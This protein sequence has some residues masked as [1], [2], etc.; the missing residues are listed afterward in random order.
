MRYQLCFCLLLT[1]ILVHGQAVRITGLVIDRVTTEPLTGASVEIAKTKF[2]KATLTDDNGRF[3]LP[4]LSTNK[5]TIT[6]K[7][8]GYLTYQ[9]TI[10]PKIDTTLRVSLVPFSQEL[11][12]VTVISAAESPVNTAQSGYNTL[13]NAQ[14]T[15]IPSIGSEHDVARTLTL[16]PGVKSDNDGSAGFYV[17][18]GTTDQNLILIDGTTLYKNNHF[19]GFLSPLNSDAIERLTLYKGGFP[20]RFGG[21]LSSVLD[22][23]LKSANKQTLR[24]GG[25]VGILSSRFVAEIPLIKNRVSLFV[26]GRR[27]YF[28]IFTRLFTG[29]GT[30]E[31][32][33]YYFFDLNAVVAAQ[34]SSRHSLKLFAY[35]DKDK[36]TGAAHNDLEDQR[37]AQT[38]NSRILGTAFTSSLGGRNSN[39]VEATWSSYQMNLLLSRQLQGQAFANNFSTAIQNR[40]IRNTTEIAFG[41]HV[42]GRLGLAQTWHTFQ[43]GRLRYEGDKL[44]LA[45][46]NLDSLNA[47]ESVIFAE[48]ELK[49]AR[50]KINLGWRFIRYAGS[51]FSYLF[52]EP[53]LSANVK[54]TQ[55]TSLKLAYARMNQPLHLLSNPGL[56][57]PVDLWFSANKTIRP[58]QSD[59]ISLGF[60]HDFTI[61]NANT[62]SV[63]AEAYYKTMANIV[64]YLDGHSSSDFTELSQQ[65]VRRWENVVTAGQGKSYGA[66]FFAEKKQ[67]RWTGWLSYTLSWTTNQ[68]DALN[69]GRS[70]FSRQDRRNAISLTGNYRLNKR[71]QLNYSW[72]CQTGQPITLPRAVYSLPAYNFI[73]GTFDNYARTV[74]VNGERNAYRM[75]DYHRL[76][77]SIQR[78]TT[79]RWGIGTWEVS[80]YNLY[81]RKN[82]YFYYMNIGQKI[83]SV[84]LFGAIPSLSYTFSIYT[85]E[86]K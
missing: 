44:L 10:T 77:V 24:L 75:K 41:E 12:P 65:T 28:D 42:L 14:L 57:I 46:S 85:G 21:R 53:R 62:I 5:Y 45:E 55:N 20:A 83:Y 60:A 54:I 32:P 27:S 66:E 49:L 2:H 22:V 78:K 76:D 74:Y 37:Y 9:Q 79:H 3:Y 36:L 33:N 68:F 17:R 19:L 59:Q 50:W 30:T 51:G 23:S 34:L 11:A 72:T 35:Q 40:T 81:N 31:G 82:P 71:W 86:R 67:G 7:Y 39:T 47:T 63:T 58:Q 70:F 73:M 8:V 1:A 4:V 6:V 52:Q 15:N 38:W 16:L 84:S 18:G 56:G 80:V 48:N 43:P 64:T 61:P 13:S 69:G 29:Y 26:A 25:T